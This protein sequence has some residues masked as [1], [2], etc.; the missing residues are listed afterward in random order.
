MDKNVCNQIFFVKN[1]YDDEEIVIF[2]NYSMF[3]PIDQRGST[4]VNLYG[5]TN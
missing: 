4:Q 1:N 3:V 5:M 2:P